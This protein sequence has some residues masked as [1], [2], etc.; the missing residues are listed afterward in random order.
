M[1]FAG[2][3]RK[4]RFIPVPNP[5]FGYLLE[6]INDL[7]ELKCTLRVIWLLH[8]KKGY[9]RYIGVTELQSDRV[10]MRG[11]AKGDLSPISELNRGLGLGVKRGTLITGHGSDQGHIYMLNTEADRKALANMSTTLD[12]KE[13][14]METESWD[15]GIIAPNIFSLYEENIGMIS[16][17]IV[18][19]LKEAELIYPQN[20]IED[21]F[22][23]AVSN[24]KRSW[25]YVVRIL[26]RWEREG[27]SDEGTIR[28]SKKTGYG[29]YFRR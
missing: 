22:R 6:E 16:P 18:E 8:Q 27:R 23:E 24:N 9:P 2:F 11:L 29:E 14:P 15:V 7:A 13:I 12:I 25:R 28:G 3:P 1:G 4:V 20:W 17:V 26:E 21:A 5:I 19:D 10:L